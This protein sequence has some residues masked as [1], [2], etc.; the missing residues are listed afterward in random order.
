MLLGLTQA[1]YKGSIKKAVPG[2]ATKYSS[3]FSLAFFSSS[4][5]QRPS[6]TS[7][8]RRYRHLRTAAR[9]LCAAQRA[10]CE[11]G[12]LPAPR[13]PTAAQRRAAAPTCPPAPSPSARRPPCSPPAAAQRTAPPPA[14]AQRPRHR[15][16][17]PGPG[18]PGGREPPP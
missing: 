7:S 3:T 2:G 10:G 16:S 12:R 6:V 9:G 13:R 18:A 1:R 8:S 14:A 17:P 15:G 11:R 5:V 4:A